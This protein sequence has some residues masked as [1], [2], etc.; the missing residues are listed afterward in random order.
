MALPKTFTEGEVLT[1]AQLNAALEYLEKLNTDLSGKVLADTGWKS[2]PTWGNAY[3][4]YTGGGHQE[5]AYRHK[6]GMVQLVGAVMKSNGGPMDDKAI[7]N[8]PANI[9]PRTVVEGAGF[10]V[11]PDGNV[12]TTYR[13]SGA[14][15]GNVV[16]FV[17]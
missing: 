8:L 10:F 4:G 15:N 13:G 17:G 12:F 1:A 7:A 6:D 3:I 2:P 9:R 5:M 11:K 14:I 16:W